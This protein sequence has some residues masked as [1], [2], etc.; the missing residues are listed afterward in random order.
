MSRAVNNKAF[1][2]I[3]VMA[4][5]TLLLF[6]I[7]SAHAQSTETNK[8]LGVLDNYIIDRVISAKEDGYVAPTVQ[9]LSKL[10]WSIGKMDI[11]NDVHIDNFLRINECELYTRFF[12]NDFEW[13]QIRAATREH[14]QTNLAT[15]PTT[16]EITNAIQLGRYNDEKQYFE[17]EEESKIEALRRLDFTMNRVIDREVCGA[18]GIK[19]GYPENLVIIM[20][21]P[22][23]VDRVFV[24]PELAELYIEESKRQYEALPARYQINVYERLAYLRLKVRILQYKDTTTSINGDPRAVVFGR[25]EGFEIYADMQMMKPLY[26][27]VYD[28]RSTRRR[29]LKRVKKK[30]VEQQDDTEPEVKAVKQE[31]E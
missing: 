29:V 30:G 1:Y 21:R 5:F 3:F 20:N 17:V 14:I 2:S 19:E 25:L 22:L 10:Y 12:H 6:D 8:K 11:N 13:Q 28:D 16:F 24:S 31:D 9:N 4:I 7:S 15:F 27:K 18:A 23:T 26:F